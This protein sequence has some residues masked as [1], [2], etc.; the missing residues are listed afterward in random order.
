MR[1]TIVRPV[2]FMENWLGMRHS[3]EGGAFSLPLDSATR[4]QM[5]AVDDIGG[6]VATALE[7]L[8]K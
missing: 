1:Y 3:I 6:V 7:R 2:F 4:L 8:G 5:V